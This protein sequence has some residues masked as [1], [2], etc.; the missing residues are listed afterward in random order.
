VGAALNWPSAMAVYAISGR[1]QIARYVRLPTRRWYD[2]SILS[3]GMSLQAFG[4][5]VGRVLGLCC[6]GTLDVLQSWRPQSSSSPKIKSDCE[7]RIILVVRSRTIRCPKYLVL[8]TE[9]RQTISIDLEIS[10]MNQL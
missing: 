8:R 5:Q 10:E 3:S 7:I 6:R 2:I 9:P 1:V 4:E